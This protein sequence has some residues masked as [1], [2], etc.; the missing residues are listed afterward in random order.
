[1]TEKEVNIKRFDGNSIDFRVWKIRVQTAMMANDCE[2]AILEGFDIA[3]S[4]KEAA[5]AKMNKKAKLIIVQSITDSILRKISKDALTDLAKDLWANIIATYESMDEFSIIFLRGKFLH[6]KQES[7]ESLDSFIAKVKRVR[8]ELESAGETVTD[9]DEIFVISHGISSEYRVDIK[10]LT[11]GKN[12]GTIKLKDFVASLLEEERL[13]NQQD[14]ETE[15][16]S[17]FYTKGK[18]SFVKSNGCYNC[19][20]KGHKTNQCRFEKNKCN[21]CGELGHLSPYCEIVKGLKDKNST[22]RANMVSETKNDEKKEKQ[23]AFHLIENK[24]SEETK[25]IFIIDSG[26]SNHTCCS[27]SRFKSINKCEQESVRV[28][29][30]GELKVK[31][32]GTVEIVT[33][34]DGIETKITINEVLYIPEMTVNLISVG[35]LIQKGLRVIFEQNECK[36][37]FGKELVANSLPWNENTKLY[38]LK[39]VDKS[40]KHGTRKAKFKKQKD[41]EGKN[42]DEGEIATIKIYNDSE[43]EDKEVEK[44]SRNSLSTSISSL[45]NTEELNNVIK[46]FAAIKIQKWY[47]K[48]KSKV[49][50]E[51]QSEENNDEKEKESKASN[52]Q[53]NLETISNNLEQQEK[54]N[55]LIIEKK[56][57]RKPTQRFEPGPDDKEIRA[58][59]K[60]KKKQ[61][62]KEDDPQDDPYS[63][64]D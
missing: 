4:G 55:P 1:M 38:E 58:K 52:E 9:R 30:Q 61:K 57:E 56:R 6:L 21:S 44:E 43:I 26:A 60:K 19:N 17:A 18:K 53:E 20:G 23:F 22:P 11:Y 31:G 5:N 24:K 42:I 14:K 34:T 50:N 45:D 59:E 62:T 16:N 48:I 47:R 39:V 63:L 46:D 49:Q 40:V 13:N 36:I 51:K 12:R 28:A 41:N 35:R 10:V 7:N 33:I 8:Q 54:V 37:M 32:I 29:D 15:T 27:K 2:D 3:E 25:D 64:F